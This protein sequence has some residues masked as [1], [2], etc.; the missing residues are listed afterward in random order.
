MDEEDWGRHNDGWEQGWYD[1]QQHQHH[2]G[3]HGGHG[4]AHDDYWGGGHIYGGQGYGS[5]WYGAGGGSKRDANDDDTRAAKRGKAAHGSL[6]EPMEEQQFHDMQVPAHLED[7]AAST[8]QDET[9]AAEA[10]AAANAAA[11]APADTGGAE[12]TDPAA[13]AAT[14]EA[15]VAEFRSVAASK[16]KDI[17]DVDL[18]AVTIPQL[19]LLATARLG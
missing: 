18:R 8:Q 9:A 14:L 12:Q 17:S 10:A 16:G 7:G 19:K 1:Q 11:S 13:Q 5:S 15:L 6:V 3:G 4:Y 2:H